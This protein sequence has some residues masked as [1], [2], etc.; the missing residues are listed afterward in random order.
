MVPTYLC[1]TSSG[2]TA[3]EIYYPFGDSI[4]FGMYNTYSEALSN[5]DAGFTEPTQI[6]YAIHKDY[7]S[8]IPNLLNQTVPIYLSKTP[9]SRLKPCCTLITAGSTTGY[10]DRTKAKDSVFFISTDGTDINNIISNYTNT[11][12]YGMRVSGINDYNNA[13]WYDIGINLNKYIGW[14]VDIATDAITAYTYSGE[15]LKSVYKKAVEEAGYYWSSLDGKGGSESFYMNMEFAD[16]R[17]GELVF[18][19]GPDPDGLD[20]SYSMENAELSSFTATPLSSLDSYLRDYGSIL[21]LTISIG[22]IH[23]VPQAE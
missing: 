1:T 14:D 4:F 10:F 9:P 3:E 23:N 19:G 15:S 16:V 22:S 6:G 7:R 21:C 12:C 11:Q 17:N 20:Q 8:I 2:E 18:H 5:I 13:A